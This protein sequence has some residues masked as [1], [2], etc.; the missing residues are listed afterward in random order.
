MAGRPFA[1]FHVDIAVGDILMEPLDEMEGKDW[2]GFAGIAPA[3]LQAISAEQQFAEKLHAYTLPRQNPNSRVRDLVDMV[4]LI[5][6]GGLSKPKLNK[7]IEGTF[8]RRKTHELPKEL[9]PPPPNWTQPFAALALD[10]GLN[11][12]I[13][14]AFNLL[15]TFF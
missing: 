6:S 13:G 12:N 3:S 10:C 9:T 5:E 15:K 2:L 7:A 11:E 1:N 4:L 14:Q 8:Q